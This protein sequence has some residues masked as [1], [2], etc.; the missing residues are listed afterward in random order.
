M[1]TLGVPLELAVRILRDDFEWPQIDA[2]YFFGQ[3]AENSFSELARITEIPRDWFDT[4]EIL[5]CGAPEEN[6]Y[7][8]RQKWSLLTRNHLR[9]QQ[10]IRS[11]PPVGT[12]TANTL[13]EA[14]GLVMMA[15]YC[16]WKRL[17]ICSTPFHQVRAF[18][19]VVSVAMREYPELM[20]WSLVGRT[21][22]WAAR[23][24]HSQGV[25]VNTRAGLIEDEEARI[26]KYQEFEKWPLASF[27]KVIRYLNCRDAA[28]T[29]F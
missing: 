26:L 27:G 24:P 15:K 5:I 19:T 13:S 4:G 16:N 14:R 17:V 12:E 3:T 7:P 1:K 29:M 2:V 8:G 11:I 20:V 23:V 22:D 21:M 9:F 6:G 18:M 28:N 10:P 25:L